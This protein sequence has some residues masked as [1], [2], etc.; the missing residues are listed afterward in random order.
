MPM[1]AV[2]TYKVTSASWPSSKTGLT[3]ARH[4]LFV[5][6]I[7]SF[8]ST[9]FPISR[10]RLPDAPS[11]LPSIYGIFLHQTSLLHIIFHLIP[12]SN[13]LSCTLCAIDFQKC[14]NNFLPRPER[15]SKH[16]ER[17]LLW[18]MQD[19]NA[20]DIEILISGII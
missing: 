1:K 5:L 17:C 20:V 6:F 7:L 4:V 3:P 8:F 9:G 2:E 19:H 12:P 11:P 18:N 10:G 16:R 13:F 15:K 14:G